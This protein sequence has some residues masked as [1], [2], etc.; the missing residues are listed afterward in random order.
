MA[1][2]GGPCLECGLDLY[3]SSARLLVHDLALIQDADFRGLLAHPRPGG[4]CD[5]DEQQGEPDAR[6][7]QAE[8][9]S[10]VPRS[11]PPT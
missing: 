10:H 6:P 4:L 2:L 8:E 5:L 7:F 3:G 1:L 9:S 11:S